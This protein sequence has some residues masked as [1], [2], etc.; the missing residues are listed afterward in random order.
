MK[1]LLSLL[2]ILMAVSTLTSAQGKKKIITENIPVRGV[3]EDC[4]ARIEKA[5]YLPGVKRA[6]WDPKTQNLKVSFKTSKVSLPE[7]EQSIARAGH[8][9]GDI[10]ATDSAYNH[11]PSCRAYK[12]K[13]LHS[14]DQKH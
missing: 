5:A 2:A 8:D 12:E 10:K 1:R 14:H 4:K 6:E 3:C 13:G 9:A 11:L 7:I